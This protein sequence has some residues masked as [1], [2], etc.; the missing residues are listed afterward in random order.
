MIIPVIIAI[1]AIYNNNVEGL[2]REGKELYDLYVSYFEIA[3]VNNIIEALTVIIIV[4]RKNILVK[5]KY[6]LYLV[7]LLTIATKVYLANGL[8]ELGSPK[9]TE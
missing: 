1:Q 3:M 9:T 8:I 2:L 7:S 5:R 6:L 4:W